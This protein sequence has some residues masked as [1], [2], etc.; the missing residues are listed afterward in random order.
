MAKFSG[1]L[2]SWNPFGIASPL[3]LSTA[4]VNLLFCPF[5]LRLEIWRLLAGVCR[6]GWESLPPGI[7]LERIP[8]PGR[9]LRRTCFIEGVSWGGGGGGCGGYNTEENVEE[10]VITSRKMWY[11]TEENVSNSEEN[12]FTSR[13]KFL[14]AC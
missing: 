10:N 14:G 2:P 7:R 8:P 13:K 1:N 5:F 9:P 4:L 6:Q 3:V 11:Y 12:N